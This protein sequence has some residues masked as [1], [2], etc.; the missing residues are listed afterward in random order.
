LLQAVL[1]ADD[2]FVNLGHGGEH[3]G[4]PKRIDK[5]DQ[6]TQSRGQDSPP[7]CLVVL[8]WRGNWFP[9]IRRVQ[10]GLL[11]AMQAHDFKQTILRI[12]IQ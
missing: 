12:T 11:F 10:E 1:V 9:G 8:P 6:S 5:Y 3:D 4:R 7:G 2:V